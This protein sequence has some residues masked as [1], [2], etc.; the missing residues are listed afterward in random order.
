MLRRPRNNSFTFFRSATATSA[1]TSQR[2]RMSSARCRRRSAGSTRCQQSPRSCCTP[3]IL[4]TFRKAEEFDDAE[5]DHRQHAASTCTMSPASTTSPTRQRQSLSRALRQRHQRR[6]LVQLR[7]QRRSLHRS[8]QRLNLRP[9]D[10]GFSGR[11]A[12]VA[13]GRLA[14]ARAFTPIVVFAHVPLWSVYPDWGWGTDD[15][16][17]RAGL[18]ETLRIGDRAQRPHSPADAEGRRQRDVSYRALHGLPAAGAGHRARP[19]PDGRSG[20]R[21]A[22]ASAT[23]RR[24]RSGKAANHSL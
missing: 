6:R 19:G 1:S 9:A 13:Q 14:A 22:H 10:L 4:R 20:R 15:C 11:A 2:T 18:S 5:P 12:R 23:S 16:G 21:I 7:P 3:A 24:S 17:S 8:R